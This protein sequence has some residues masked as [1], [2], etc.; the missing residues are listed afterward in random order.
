M[1]DTSTL[2]IMPEATEADDVSSAERV[3]FTRSERLGIFIRQALSTYAYISLHFSRAIVMCSELSP[4][5]ARG[6]YMVTLKFS[7]KRCDAHSLE[8]KKL[9]TKSKIETLG[10]S[11]VPASG[12][13]IWPDLGTN[14]ITSAPR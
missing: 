12:S 14:C 10:K 13:P 1:E 6:T 7:R 4:R 9:K 3:A 2:L 5:H 8:L 11:Q